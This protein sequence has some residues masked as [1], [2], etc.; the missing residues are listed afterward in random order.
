MISGGRICLFPKQSTWSIISQH[1]RVRSASIDTSVITAAGP[2]YELVLW[3]DTI[4][5][6]TSTK[7]AHRRPITSCAIVGVFDW[8]RSVAPLVNHLAPSIV[9]KAGII[10]FWISRVADA[11]KTVIRCVTRGTEKVGDGIW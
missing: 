3:V 5:S 4:P 9:G 11:A 10:I 1:R 2:I 6:S 7:R 8:H